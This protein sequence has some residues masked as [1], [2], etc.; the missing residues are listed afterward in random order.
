MQ[1]SLEYI[2]QPSTPAGSNKDDHSALQNGYTLNEIDNDVG[3]AWETSCIEPI[4]DQLVQGIGARG[5]ASVGQRL[6]QALI[7]EDK[8]DNITNNIYRSETYPFDTHEIH[9]EE[10]GWKSHSQGYKLESLMNFEAAGKGSNGL[11]LD[12]DWKYHDELSHKGN[13]A[14]EK[15]K[16]WPEFQYSEMCFSDRIIIELSEVGV[17]IEPVVCVVSLFNCIILYNNFFC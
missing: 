1:G 4:L 12:S 9:F 15:A 17:S 10:G 2:S 11:M 16:V 13:N 8:V 6:M 5:G 3:I 7:D 14:M